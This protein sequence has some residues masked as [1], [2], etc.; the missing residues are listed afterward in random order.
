M[1][2]YASAFSGFSVDDLHKAKEFYGTAL[3]LP[4]REMPEGLSLNLPG[5]DVFIYEKKD[6]LPATFT[7]LNFRTTDIDAAADELKA[8]GIELERYDMGEMRPDEKGI[9]RSESPED[10]PSI[11]WFLDPA[12]NVLSLVSDTR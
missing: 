5:T 6:H 2:T 3:K 12:G 11:A 9:Y 4:L 10:G 1:H 8:S 7:V